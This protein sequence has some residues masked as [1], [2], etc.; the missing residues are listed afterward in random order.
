MVSLKLLVL[1]LTLPHSH[2]FETVRIETSVK[3]FV[4]AKFLGGLV[5]SF[6]REFLVIF[7]NHTQNYLDE[8]RDT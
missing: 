4:F 6:V 2:S 8:N 7:G 1:K 3:Y 5:F